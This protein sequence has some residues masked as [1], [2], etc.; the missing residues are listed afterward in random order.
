MWMCEN[1]LVE[2]QQG[3]IFNLTIVLAVREINLIEQ[4]KK[5]K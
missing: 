4:N 2:G 3:N 1:N 5:E